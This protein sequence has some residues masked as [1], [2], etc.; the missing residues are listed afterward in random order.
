ML[1]LKMNGMTAGIKIT[2]NDYVA[3]IKP[4]RCY[5]TG[6]C[7]NIVRTINTLAPSAG[8]NGN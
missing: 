2:T 1:L 5:T 4:N 8:I 7:Q 3:A 6:L